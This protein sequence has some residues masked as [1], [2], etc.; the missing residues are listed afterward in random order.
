[1]FAP[2]DSAEKKGMFV[3]YALKQV[4]INI[5]ISEIRL[6]GIAMN[7]LPNCGIPFVVSYDTVYKGF[8]PDRVS[9]FFCYRTL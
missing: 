9:D 1:M 7:V 6:H 2:T 8:L 4:E 5:V 3:R